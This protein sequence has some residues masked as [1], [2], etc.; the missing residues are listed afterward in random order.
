MDIHKLTK[1]LYFV[2]TLKDIM[3]AVG[4]Q[5]RKQPGKVHSP[6][7]AP[8]HPAFQGNLIKVSRVTLTFAASILT[9][10]KEVLPQ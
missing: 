5:E 10:L 7:P 4:T 3:K 1:L 8:S 2:L 6:S 9:L